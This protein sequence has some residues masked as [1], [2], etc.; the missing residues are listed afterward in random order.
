MGNMTCEGMGLI[1]ARQK[2]ISKAGLG[3]NTESAQITIPRDCIRDHFLGV[4]LS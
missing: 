3:Q 2:G 1:W 4:F